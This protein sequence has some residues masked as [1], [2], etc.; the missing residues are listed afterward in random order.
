MKITKDSTL[1]EILEIKG[2]QEI[3]SKHNI[4]C[5]TCP[6]A[7]IEMEKL[8]L[9]DICKNYNIK[10]KGLLEDLEKLED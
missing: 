5:V 7:K 9:E 1:K 6:F 3:L 2:A 10:I 4:P 8:R